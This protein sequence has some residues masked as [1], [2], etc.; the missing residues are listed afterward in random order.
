MTLLHIIFFCF[1]CFICVF[2]PGVG[3]DGF[4]GIDFCDVSSRKVYTVIALAKC[5]PADQN[6]LRGCTAELIC[7]EITIMEGDQI[8]S[9]IIPEMEPVKIFS[10]LP[11]R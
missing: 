2:V 9:R 5:G 10:T 7:A 1:C 4:A 8:F 6:T 3:A 11:N